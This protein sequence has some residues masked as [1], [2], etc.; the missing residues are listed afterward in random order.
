MGIALR[1]KTSQAEWKKVI[2]R[3]D[4]IAGDSRNRPDDYKYSVFGALQL[5]VEEL[6]E[7]EGAAFLALEPFRS[8]VPIPASLAQLAVEEAAGK[9]YEAEDFEYVMEGLVGAGLVLYKE[10]ADGVVYV[11]LDLPAMFLADRVTQKK[12]SILQTLFAGHRRR[13]SRRRLLAAFLTTY[14]QDDVIKPAE[15]F[16]G[17]SNIASPEFSTQTSSACALANQ[18]SKGLKADE[19]VA[20]VLTW[21][22]WANQGRVADDLRTALADVSRADMLRP[23]D[24]FTLRVQGTIRR[25]LGLYAD[26]LQPFEDAIKLNPNDVW[27]QRFRRSVLVSLG[28]GEEVL[29]ELDAEL[30]RSPNDADV[31][32]FRGD[33]KRRMGRTDEALKD[34]NA[35]V[36][37]AGNEDDAFMLGVRGEIFRLLGQYDDA[38]RDLNRACQLDHSDALALQARGVVKWKLGMDLDSAL[39]DLEKSRQLWEDADIHTYIAAV[40]YAKGDLKGAQG[41]SD[42]AEQLHKDPGYVSD[43]TTL[44]QDLKVKLQNARVVGS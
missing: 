28:R 10:D 30:K 25:R 21:R 13:S 44:L 12:G 31:L 33:I 18:I 19:V 3:L 16:L 36:T 9:T 1:G 24:P 5:A 26:A 11:L 6:K 34:M 39:A 38:L 4:K 35:A 43:C 40:K 41:H 20:A 23:K 8:A 7:G 15:Q 29:Q 2:R 14:G 22:A 37:A 27:S 17:Y 42:L 32:K